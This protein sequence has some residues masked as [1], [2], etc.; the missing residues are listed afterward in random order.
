VSHI[1][2]RV[3]KLLNET[4]LPIGEDKELEFKVAF[5]EFNPDD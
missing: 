1:D 5:A 2:T 3:E 4:V